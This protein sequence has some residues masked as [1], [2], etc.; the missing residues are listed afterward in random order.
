MALVTYLD[1]LVEFFICAAVAWSSAA[2]VL[3]WHPLLVTV[4]R[5]CRA[6]DALAKERRRLLW[7]VAFTPVT[8]ALSLITYIR[9]VTRLWQETMRIVP[10]SFIIGFLNN[11]LTFYLAVVLSMGILGLAATV[12]ILYRYRQ[13]LRDLMTIIKFD[14]QAAH[15]AET[16]GFCLFDAGES[17]P[18]LQNRR[19]SMIDEEREALAIE[20]AVLADT[21]E[22]H[23]H[24]DRRSR[25]SNAQMLNQRR[26]SFLVD[27]RE[28]FLP[29]RRKLNLADF[30]SQCLGDTNHMPSAKRKSRK[31]DLCD[32]DQDFANNK[33]LS[34]N[35][36]PSHRPPSFDISLASEEFGPY[37]DFSHG[38]HL[39][40][41]NPEDREARSRSRCASC[42]SSHANQISCVT[43]TALRRPISVSPDRERAA[44]RRLDPTFALQQSKQKEPFAEEYGLVMEDMKAKDLDHRSRLIPE[45]SS[46]FPNSKAPMSPSLAFSW[47]SPASQP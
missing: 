2:L 33:H 22:V 5:L 15:G 18:S 19:C 23:S 4:L 20:L 12:W 29:Q 21:R 10:K 28:R 13:S 32:D 17:E 38:W 30:E 3:A 40:C 47:A 11:I 9:N 6:G 41:I 1:I 24:N 27:H 35:P 8:W 45:S 31:Q 34:S 44:N 7:L 16:E 36:G 37:Y 46:H 39:P 25:D 42:S 43:K 14:P 26:S